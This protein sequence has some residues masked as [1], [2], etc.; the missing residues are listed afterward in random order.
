M[1][2]KSMQPTSLTELPFGTFNGVQVIKYTLTNKSGMQVSILN[3]GGTI[4]QIITPD[5]NN[6]PGDVVL[7]YESLSGFLQKENPYF[8]CLVGRYANRIAKG[9]FTLEGKTY[10]L[11]QNNDGNSLHGGNTGFD[12]VIWDA[13]KQ[14]ETNSLKL[15]Y[16]S[17]DGEEGYPGNLKVEVVYTLTQDNA[18][19]INYTATTDKPTPVNL[20]NHCY[21]NLSAGKSPTI[22]DHQLMIKADKFTPVDEQLIP[23][24]QLSDVNG[25]PMDFRQE[26]PIGRDIQQLEGGYDHNWVLNKDE[27]SLEKIATVYDPLSG[28]LMEVYTTEPAMQFYSAN[29]LDGTLKDTKGGQKYGRHAALCLETQHYPD[30]PNQPSFPNTI[31]R[32]GE[33]YLQT[34]IYKFLT[35]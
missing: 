10:H 25:T 9:Q 1:E 27:N 20:T 6:Q 5:K 14:P 11:A 31:L 19:K 7:G 17:K 28:R 2:E 23:T 13:Q 24:G 18:L 35:R 15:T 8:N 3:Y 32:P 21:F 34:T 22:L 30:S 12:K 16:I 29:F 33:T 26:K 4:T